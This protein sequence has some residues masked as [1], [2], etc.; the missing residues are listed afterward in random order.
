M[1]IFFTAKDNNKTVNNL[2]ELVTYLKEVDYLTLVDAFPIE[3]KANFRTTF[4]PVIEGKKFMM[5]FK[6]E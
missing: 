2:D 4:A 6:M 5:L 1:N 3:F